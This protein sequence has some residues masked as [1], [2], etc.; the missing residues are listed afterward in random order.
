MFAR[1]PGLAALVA[2]AGAVRRPR[3]LRATGAARARRAGGPAADRRADRRGRGERLRRARRQGV[4]ARGA[5]ARA[6]PARRPAASSTRRWSRRGCS[7]FYKP[8]I[9]FLPQLG[10]AAILL[11]GG[12]QVIHGTLTLGDFTAFY[13]Y[14][15]MLLAPMRTLGIVARHGAARDGLGR[16]A[17]RDP[18]PRA[19]R[20]RRRRRAAAA[21]R[22]RAASSCA[23][24]R[25]RYEG[26]RRPALRDV[27]AR[28]RR[29]ARRSRSSAPTGSGKTTLVALLAAP[30]R[31][32]P[33]ARC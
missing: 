13:A 20:S 10:L 25:S 14:L 24:S 16:A 9:G 15:L 6:L 26:A 2:R 8:L 11:V 4:R 22:A 31:R 30:L 23:T 12:R 17:L 3:R 19:A 5:P 7:A 32:R 18:R 1:R 29:R 28:R 27:V 33:R 21:A